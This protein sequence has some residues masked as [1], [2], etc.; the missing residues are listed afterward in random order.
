[1]PWNGQIVMCFTL[2]L[3]S[4]IAKLGDGVSN[5][6]NKASFFHGFAINLEYCQTNKQPLLLCCLPL[7]C[8]LCFIFV[9][10]FL[11]LFQ[12]L[13]AS[14]EDEDIENTAPSPGES[15][16]GRVILTMIPQETQKSSI[17][18]HRFTAPSCPTR[19]QE[20]QQEVHCHGENQGCHHQGPKGQNFVPPSPTGTSDG[21]QRCHLLSRRT[22]ALPTKSLPM[23]VRPCNNKEFPSFP[24]NKEVMA[25]PTS[26]TASPAEG[27][28]M[29]ALK[30]PPPQLTAPTTQF[31]NQSAPTGGVEYSISEAIANPSQ[32]A[33]AASAK[34]EF[35]TLI[36]KAIRN[37]VYRKCKLVVGEKTALVLTEMVL[38]SLQIARFQGNDPETKARKADW[39]KKWKKLCCQTLNSVCG[40]AQGCLRAAFEDYRKA[41]GVYVTIKDL[42]NCAFR[43][44]DP[45]NQQL[46]KLMA[47]YMSISGCQK[48]LPMNPT[49]VKK[50]ADTP[51]SA[52]Q[53][54]LQ[55]L[56]R[57]CTCTPP[58]KQ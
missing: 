31:S 9:V 58:L 57:T 1:M 24:H 30:A 49:G 29:P 22:R 35:R 14:D 47:W 25:P 53:S 33:A 48:G 41:N 4:S 6:R 18:S 13:S 51:Q 40:Y 52:K 8:L 5:F 10:D 39:C 20:L 44:L 28:T 42:K 21:S 7:L 27:A 37:K 55:E 46:V 2:E 38:D 12:E 45:N 11:F 16:H 43:L 15:V 17:R 36:R 32:V 23:P 54:P 3:S 26:G 34:Q 56:P 19:I 50:S